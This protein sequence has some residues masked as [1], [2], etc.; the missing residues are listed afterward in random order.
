MGNV[1][2][3]YII[4]LFSLNDILE[5]MVKVYYEVKNWFFYYLYMDER[6]VINGSK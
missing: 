1:Y 5:V 2:I 6:V 3:Y 4:K